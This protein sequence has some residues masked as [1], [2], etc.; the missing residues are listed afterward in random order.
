MAVDMRAELQ[1]CAVGRL[2]ATVP[3][4]QVLACV[5]G[6]DQLL[7][8]HMQSP[9]PPQEGP[10]RA[11]EVAALLWER[12]LVEALRA[13]CCVIPTSPDRLMCN[14]RALLG[15]Q[16]PGGPALGSGEEVLTA[17]V[18]DLL[19]EDVERQLQGQGQGLLE[20]EGTV[21]ATEEEGLACLL[22][23]AEGAAALLHLRGQAWAAVAVGHGPR[24]AGA[25]LVRCV[26]RLLRGLEDGSICIRRLQWLAQRPG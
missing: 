22:S 23:Y 18:L 17:H 5:R 3:V 16:W 19:V 11:A 10:S 4:A 9:S 2:K 21:S 25:Q 1:R 13:S 6:L 20:I 12:W 7:Q 15:P 24:T 14:V 26:T 8:Q